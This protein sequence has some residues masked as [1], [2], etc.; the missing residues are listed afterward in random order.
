M[1][2]TGIGIVIDSTGAESGARRYRGSADDIINSS[3]AIE[4]GISG[5]DGAFGALKRELLSLAAGFS[6]F[7]VLE[8]SVRKFSD[9]DKALIAVGKTTNISGDRLAAL[10]QSIQM[11]TRELPN[12]AQE[13]L[14]IAT[15]AGQLG[16]SGEKNILA[17]T[18]TVAKLGTATDLAGEKAATT[19]ARIL[20]VTKEGAENV[21]RLGSVL[22]ALG[23]TSAATESEIASMANE[24]ASAGAEFGVSSTE[25]AA[26]G[27]AF[28][29]MGARAE[30]TASVIGK[31]MREI[32]SATRYGGEELRA[33]Q[34]ITGQT[35]EQIRKEFAESPTK[36]FKTFVEG[37]ARIKKEG[38]DVSGVLAKLNLTGDE[39]AKVL[40]VA[41]SNAALLGEKLALANKEAKDGTA[42]QKEFVAASKSFS[43]QMDI[44]SNRFD[45]VFVALGRELA[46]ALLDV[47]DGMQAW[48]SEA[49]NV[50]LIKDVIEGIGT[51][52]KALSENIGTVTKAI[53]ALAGT[54]ASIKIGAVFNAGIAGAAAYTREITTMAAF[55]RAVAQERVID[56]ARVVAARQAELAVLSK[57]VIVH[58]NATIAAFAETQAKRALALAEA[59]HAAAL[60][61]VSVASRAAAIGMATAGVA[62]RG[63]GFALRFFGGI[64]GLILTAVTALALFV[65]W[66]DKAEATTSDV[67]KVV[68]SSNDAFKELIGSIDGVAG[69][70]SGLVSRT[71]EAA[72][73]FAKLT[74]SAQQAQRLE[75]DA[76]IAKASDVIADA[77]KK[78]NAAIGILEGKA[79]DKLVQA[80]GKLSEG[81]SKGALAIRDTGAGIEALIGKYRKG[82]LSSVAFSQ[83]LLEQVESSGRAGARYREMAIGISD[84][85]LKIKT[86]KDELG[87]LKKASDA[88]SAAEL[89]G[90]STPEVSP[91]KQKEYIAALTKIRDE[92]GDANQAAT[93]YK[94]RL[95]ALNYAYDTG[96]VS[97]AEY[98][99]LNMQINSIGSDR[100]REEADL[101]TATNIQREVYNNLKKSGLD[102]DLA[103]INSQG[104][105]IGGL[106]ALSAARQNEALAIEQGTK[107]LIQRKGQADFK[108]EIRSLTIST[109]LIQKQTGATKAR[110]MALAF[111]AEQEEKGNK[112]SEEQLGL[113]EQGY[114]KHLQV[115]TARDLQGTIDGLQ[116]ENEIL[117]LIA[118]GEDRIVATLIVKAKLAGTYNDEMEKGFDEVR[119][120]IEANQKL[121][122]VI[123]KG[124]DI[125]G[126][127]KY[128][129]GSGGT[130]GGSSGGGGSN[131]R[132]NGRGFDMFNSIY[133]V[134]GYQS[135]TN[136]TTFGWGGGGGGSKVTFVADDFTTGRITNPGSGAAT[137]PGL[138]SVAETPALADYQMAPVS[139]QET[140][141]TN[142]FNITVNIDGAVED[143]AETA[144]QIAR[145]SATE[146]D[147]LLRRN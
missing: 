36:A 24:I 23:N 131:T 38:G 143:S 2:E 69:R 75:I 28:R 121:N 130:G 89:G 10:G 35:A 39:V 87:E 144:D 85:V 135:T 57:S 120:L 56:S 30:L 111:A 139:T 114:Q 47:A 37:L 19:L 98:L 64:P 88:L 7:K 20:T 6:A 49:Q 52:A 94:N 71:N 72:G 140:A 21:G 41:A 128:G 103:E 123:Q 51:A 105:I 125:A 79:T 118:K 117:K 1:E 126:S 65:D 101:L 50:Q 106:D 4:R 110:A 16:V 137:Q 66:S 70:Y 145:A 132:G 122:D 77:T 90:G 44:L 63:L 59:Q 107:A 32:A 42:L 96:R 91:E 18:D 12:S 138:R 14:D 34:E 109:A 9:F 22:V 11:M 129:G 13:L 102:I 3:K 61:A 99:S 116:Q 124:N 141:N 48:L 81:A 58:G 55:E 33:L 108:E 74:K 40:P 76:G 113:L 119:R 29:S 31:T 84:A 5:V 45:E 82:E 97:A 86:M 25:A 73:A 60:T 8:T 54:Y 15:A 67:E 100:L 46:P 112:L 104:Q 17:F 92:F 134:P 147:R 53:L 95:E 68:K 80:V 62:A 127:R 83:A 78:L 26:L 43:A 146:I 115:Q 93:E 142:N 136:W 133:D 27:A